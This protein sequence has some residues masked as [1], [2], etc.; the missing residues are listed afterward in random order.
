MRP[1]SAPERAE[2]PR[3]KVRSGAASFPKITTGSSAYSGNGLVTEA[4]NVSKR[5]TVRHLPSLSRTRSF[6]LMVREP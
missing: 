1:S 2:G 4:R 3:E 5:V 6:Q